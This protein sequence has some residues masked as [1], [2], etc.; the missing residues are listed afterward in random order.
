MEIIEAA[1]KILTSSGVSG[2][3][4]KNL[5]K[6]MGFSESAIYRHFESKEEII[7]SMLHFLAENMDTR[8]AQVTRSHKCP[9]ENFIA[10][11]DNQFTFFKTHPH[12]VVAV[13][14]DGLM[15]ESQSINAIILRLMNIKKKYLIPIISDGQKQG[16][17][18]QDISHENLM[19]IILGA[20]RLQ[21]LK[22]KIARFDFDIV[23]QGT[24]MTRSLLTLIKATDHS[25]NN[26]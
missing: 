8:L 5:S 16:H 6:E 15:E 23:Q 3:T 25:K 20:F 18:T 17:F 24:H 22:W 12:F 10:L 4:I 13:F 9:K 1:G 26:K 2:L 7:L 11:F 21:M 14:S 19:H